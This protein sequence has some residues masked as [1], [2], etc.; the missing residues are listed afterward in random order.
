LQMALAGTAIPREFTSNI[1]LQN[2]VGRQ[3][4]YEHLLAHVA[5]LG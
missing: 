1:L 5:P 2:C 3:T 4:V